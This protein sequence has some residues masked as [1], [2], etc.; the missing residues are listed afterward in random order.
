M[1]KKMNE[2]QT[3]NQKETHKDLKSMVTAFRMI[4]TVESFS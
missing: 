2:V 4:G 3:G 1:M